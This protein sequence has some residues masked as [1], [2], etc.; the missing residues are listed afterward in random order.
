MPTAPESA[1]RETARGQPDLADENAELG[2]AVGE[3][4][5]E[6]AELSRRVGELTAELKLEQARHEAWAKEMSVRERLRT[7]REAALTSRVDDLEKIVAE[8]RDA[9]EPATAARRVNNRA[10]PEVEKKSALVYSRGHGKAAVEI[11]G[12]GGAAGSLISMVGTAMESTVTADVAGI[13]GG[14]LGV[15]AA[16][17]ALTRKL[18]EE[19]RDDR[20]QG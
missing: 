18:K 14:V 4:S 17:I 3:L 13:A 7:S 1:P 20:H 2:R 9:I 12:T 19:R 8:L 16:G 10:A 11:A 5:S 15:F 6:N